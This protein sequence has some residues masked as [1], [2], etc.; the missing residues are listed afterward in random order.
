MAMKLRA[1]EQWLRL[2][3]LTSTQVGSAAGEA[4][5]D[6][7]TQKEAQFGLPY[8][9]DSALKG[10]LAAPL[11]DVPVE[12]D[13]DE[14]GNQKTNPARERVFGRPDRGTV[15]GRPARLVVGNGELLCFPVPVHQGPP[16]WVFPAAAV[17]RFLALDPDLPQDSNRTDAEQLLAQVELESDKRRCFAFPAWPRLAVDVGLG[18]LRGVSVRRNRKALL[19]VLRRYAGAA[20]PEKAAVMVAAAKVAGSLWRQAAEL[21]TLTAVDGETRTVA[22]A[23]LRRVE[24]IPPGTVFLSLVSLGAEPDGEDQLALE[25][26]LVQVGARESLG[27]GCVAASAVDGVGGTKD[28]TPDPG[29]ASPPLPQLGGHRWMMEAH[30]AVEA[31]RATGEEALLDK[32]KSAVDKLG[33]RVRFG[34]VESAVAFSLAK[35][36]P[37]HAEPKAEARAHRWML[38]FVLGLGA[39]VPAKEG[40]ATRLNAWLE[41]EPFE[42]E[43]LRQQEEAILGRWLWLRRFSEFGF[44]EAPPEE[45][46]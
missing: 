27:F 20:L 16:A 13:T 1:G 24:L 34:G 4:T 42:G 19:A 5:L 32:A 41:S 40:A 45:A 14:E 6:R 7:P 2:E 33:P 8:L 25:P 23:T 46:P 37:R 18:E 12:G 15:P 35:A 36:K 29:E 28:E 10:V 39:E 44:E 38:G 22:G 9:P 17:S 43:T 26:P 30:A 3:T 21:R 31:L 11:G